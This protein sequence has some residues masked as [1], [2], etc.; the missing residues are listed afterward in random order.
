MISLDTH[1]QE[2]SARI[3]VIGVGGGGGNAINNMIEKGLQGVDFIVANTD[4]QALDY[5]RADMRI[6]LGKQ[7]TKGLGAGADPSVGKISV[8]ESV[9]DIK[10]MLDKADMVFITAGMGGGTGTGGAPEIAKIARSMDALTV[11]IVTT[12]FH[13]EGKRRMEVAEK[14]IAELRQNVDALIVIPNQKLLEIIDKKTSFKEAFLTVDEVLYNATRGISDIISQHGVVNV[15][16]ADVRTVMKDMGD[17]L[18]GIGVATGDN[19]AIEATEKAIKS[20]L[21]DGISIEGSKGVLVNITGGSDLTMFEVSEAVQIVES[22]AGA[23]ANIIHGVVYNDEMEGEIMVTVVATGFN[24]DKEN[25]IKEEENQTE[26][27]M[28]QESKTS[29]LSAK[30]MDSGPKGVTQLKN[31]DEPTFLRNKG[32]AKEVVN[33][34]LGNAFESKRMELH[35]GNKE[36]RTVEDKVIEKIKEDN[37]SMY[38]R[39][40][41]IRKMMQE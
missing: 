31:Y 18:M 4:N 34:K 36:T 2:K 27:R 32:E 40:A 25:N 24:K 10:K 20:P 21:L 23:N 37:Y 13:W 28:N 7:K 5:N 38:E 11:A 1:S 35:N 6:Q 3:K 33:S 17:A 15:D 41:F 30:T 22:A 9:E 8:E 29:F 39:P 16:F 26:R 12:P 14:W 19:R